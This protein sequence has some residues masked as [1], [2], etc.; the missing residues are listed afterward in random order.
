MTHSPRS[1]EEDRLTTIAPAIVIAL[2]IGAGSL[3][4]IGFGPRLL[5]AIA[6]YTAM[7]VLSALTGTWMIVQRPRDSAQPPGE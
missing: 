5:A 6:V 7:A 1:A 4:G 2:S 3:L